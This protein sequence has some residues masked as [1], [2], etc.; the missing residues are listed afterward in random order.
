MAI[1]M[2]LRKGYPELVSTQLPG[3]FDEP[4]ALRGRKSLSLAEALSVA[5]Q[6]F[7]CRAI[8]LFGIELH[9]LHQLQDTKSRDVRRSRTQADFQEMAHRSCHLLPVQA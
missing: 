2:Y 7:C 1:N 4:G 5:L 6:Y 8:V 9:G 3:K